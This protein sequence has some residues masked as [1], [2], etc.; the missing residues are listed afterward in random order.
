MYNAG[1]LI[2]TI[3]TVRRPLQAEEG[4]YVRVM[5]ELVTQGELTPMH[6]N[7][8]FR[9]GYNC[10]SLYLGNGSTD[11]REMFMNCSTSRFL[12]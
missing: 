3:S 4:L 2:M 8:Q 6:G 12:S 9:F 5:H 10:E 11:G 7:G 1:L